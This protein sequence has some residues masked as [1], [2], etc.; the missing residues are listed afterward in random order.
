MLFEDL[1]VVIPVTDEE[2]RPIKQ[3]LE[4]NSELFKESFLVVIDGGL[5]NGLALKD[6]AHTYL[7]AEVHFWEARKLGYTKVETPFTL[8][9]DSDVILPVDYV[10]DALTLLRQ[11]KADAVAIFHEDVVECQGA[12]AYGTSLWK[13]EILQKLYDFSMLKVADGKIVKVGSMAYATLNNGWCEC[14]YMFRKL[15]AIN[16]RLETLPYRAVHLK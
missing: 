6:S 1:T 14:T 2:P 8:N 16:G 7:V 9:L 13:T 11:N 4:E 5:R 3:F 10:K 15:K 12:L